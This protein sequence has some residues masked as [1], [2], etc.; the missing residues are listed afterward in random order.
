M[1]IDTQTS[2]RLLTEIERQQKYLDR[3]PENFDFPLFNAA[4]AL[5]SQRR[6]GYRNTAAAA[7]EIV[8]NAME[9][10][11]TRID[12]CFAKPKQLQ[13]PPAL[14]VDQCD[15]V[16]RQRS[17]MIPKMAQ[18]ALSWGGHPLRRS[19][20]HRQVRLRPAQRFDQS[21]SAGRGLHQGAA[22][23][24]ITK[25]MARRPRGKGTRPP[26]RSPT[27]SRRSAG[28]RPDL[29]RQAGPGHSSTARWLS[30]LNRIASPTGSPRNLMKRAPRRRFRRHLPLPARQAST[31]TS[32]A[33][34]WNRS[35]RCS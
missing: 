18:Y 25:A 35:I 34:R 17:G 27:P 11:A 8:D 5:E 33:P 31:S 13:G 19:D 14:R 30:G 23:T 22:T 32:R 3:L 28:L 15:R 16:H 1:T 20:L 26:D 29:P 6:S 21:D 7:R 4:Q 9:A 2:D 12:I 10:G 24:P